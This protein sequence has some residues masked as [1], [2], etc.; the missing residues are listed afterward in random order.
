MVRPADGERI[1][2]V[3]NLTSNFKSVDFSERGESTLLY[4]NGLGDGTGIGPYG[5]HI[6]KLP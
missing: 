6:Y 1:L 5:T 4:R 2:V 3:V